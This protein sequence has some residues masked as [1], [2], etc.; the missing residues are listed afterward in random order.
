MNI[1]LV[2]IHAPFFLLLFPPGTT[3]QSAA[4]TLKIQTAGTGDEIRLDSA[5]FSGSPTHPLIT[6]GAKGEIKQTGDNNSIDINSKS[7]KSVK[8][9]NQII[10]QQ[11]GKNNSV[12][13]NSK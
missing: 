2:L 1:Q 4:H 3:G 5:W 6:T 8:T 10:I 12:K 11:T 9:K 13:I 7:T